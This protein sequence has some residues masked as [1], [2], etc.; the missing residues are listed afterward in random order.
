MRNHEDILADLDAR[1][2]EAVRRRETAV[3]QSLRTIDIWDEKT[4]PFV[5]YVLWLGSVKGDVDSLVRI[6]CF[7][8]WHNDEKKNERYDKIELAKYW[9]RLAAD[10][11]Y[12]D[13]QYLLGLLL[14][15]SESDEVSRQA[16]P[17]FEK[18]SDQG[19][20]AAMRTLAN[21]LCCGKC[22]REDVPRAERLKKRADELEDRDKYR[23]ADAKSQAREGGGDSAMK[24]IK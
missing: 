10:R 20:V 11:G 5:L 8:D 21:C 12:A 17:L 3:V 16:I 14:R 18:A 24:M 7:F 6:G 19:H 4:M 22:V 9:Y 2:E 13:G 23:V 1:Y 15:H